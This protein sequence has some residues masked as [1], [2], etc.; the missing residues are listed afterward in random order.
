M[1]GLKV[2]GYKKVLL[3]LIVCM[4]FIIICHI[5]IAPILGKLKIKSVTCFHNKMK[6]NSKINQ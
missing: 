6:D 5:W 3:K 4:N 2:L 1:N